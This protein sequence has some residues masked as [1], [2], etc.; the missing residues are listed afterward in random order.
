MFSSGYFF[1]KKNVFDSYRYICRKFK[2]LIFPIYSYNFFYRFLIYLPKKYVYINTIKPFNFINLFIEPLGGS[3][4]SFI[5]TSWFSSTLFF[6]EVY[7][8]VKRQIVKVIK[9]EPN[10][11][12]YLII[13]LFISCNCIIL[14]NK[15]YNKIN[16]INKEKSTSE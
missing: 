9:I 1:K 7:N 11:L 2:R 5:K 16:L 3:R 6:V 12:I 14:S 10:E 4:I 8:I 15:G 13:D